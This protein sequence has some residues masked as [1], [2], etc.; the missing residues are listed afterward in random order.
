MRRF[1]ISDFGFGIGRGEMREVP[2]G[3]AASTFHLKPAPKRRSGFTLIELIGV[4]AIIGILSA[5]VLPPMIAKIEEAN[6][7]N[8][9]AAQSTIA[10]AILK[11]IK[12][13]ATF[14]NPNKLPED[15]PDGW[16]TL[17]S[18]FFPQSPAV[19]RYVFP[20]DEN[21]QD[22][23]RRVYL[24]PQLLAYLGSNFSQP[25]VGY[26]ILDVNPANGMPDVEENALRLYIVSSSKPNLPLACAKNS[27][28]PGPQPATSYGSA[29]INDLLGWVKA[30]EA[31]SSDN[32]GSV[33]VPTTIANWSVV[34]AS[35]S[36]RGE[37]LHVKIVALRDI[38]KKVTLIDYASPPTAVVP[39][40]GQGGGGGANTYRSVFVDSIQGGVTYRFFTESQG[41][42]LIISAGRI[43][44]IQANTKSMFSRSTFNLGGIS[45]TL[46]DPATT[47]EN[48]VAYFNLSLPNAPW[49]QISSL[50]QQQMPT[51][52]NEQSFY[53][54]SGSVLSLYNNDPN[55]ATRRRILS[56]PINSDAVFE[57]YNGF[58]TRKD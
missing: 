2:G 36:R 47:T 20:K 5:V 29:L 54:I 58:W 8:E 18:K 3:S 32:A 17:A 49:W 50:P 44:Q 6:T 11:G 38:F 42:H 28:S 4:M 25:A 43:G 34:N 12:A 14:P 46:D 7:V 51:N 41:S 22:T 23:E 55:V 35:T 56:T 31:V 21:F 15:S 19:L 30:Y 39:N 52:L 57:Y 9:D 27:A 24:D 10:D 37:F 13:Y 1:W 48:P 53:V 45:Y 16:V 26:S 40:G 33:L